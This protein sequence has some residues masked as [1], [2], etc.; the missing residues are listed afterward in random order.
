MEEWKY[1]EGHDGYEISNQGRVRSSRK[2]G[3][4]ILSLAQMPNGYVK[5]NL[6]DGKQ[7]LVH[8]LVG[9]AFLP[10]PECLPEID[11]INRNRQDNRIENLRWSCRS[12]NRLN[13]KDRTAHRNITKWTSSGYDYWVVQIQRN[14]VKLVCKNFKT[15]EDAIHYRD[16]WLQSANL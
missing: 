2:G 12:K 7:C 6:T 4:H 1:I 15:L 5:V 11:H 14:N 10:N 9:M 13:T 3:L 8:R 16:E